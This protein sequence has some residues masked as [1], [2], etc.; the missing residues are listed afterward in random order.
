MVHKRWVIGKELIVRIAGDDDIVGHRCIGKQ[1]VY[2]VSATALEVVS[3][4]FI[5]LEFLHAS[6]KVNA[7][8]AL[9]LLLFFAAEL[10]DSEMFPRH[11]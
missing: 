11:I 10:Q 9:K 5:D 8:Y 4:C 6:L 3:A 1:S 2:P 7:S